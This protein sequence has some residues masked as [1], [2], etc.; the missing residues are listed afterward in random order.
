M[1]FSAMGRVTTPDF[2]NGCLVPSSA[3]REMD[4]SSKESSK[5]EISRVTA[6]GLFDAA[7][8][9]EGKMTQLMPPILAVVFRKSSLTS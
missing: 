1:G 7:G 6:G 4:W 8:R 5:I 2:G 3:V 9:R